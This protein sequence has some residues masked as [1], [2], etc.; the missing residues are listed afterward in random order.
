MT[1]LRKLS[2]FYL[3]AASAFTMAAVLQQHPDWSR[4]A[5]AAA[6]SIR[7]TTG[8]AATALNQDVI[9]PGWR[10][11]KS[12]ASAFNSGVLQPGWTFT[13]TQSK[14]FAAWMLA[15]LAP[16]PVHVAEAKK[17]QPAKRAPVVP[18][19]K[20]PPVL[21]RNAAPVLRPSITGAQPKV[22]AE[23]APA[24]M[25]LAPQ[26]PMAAP[27]PDLHPPGQAEIARVSERLRD[28]LTPDMLDHFSLFLFVSKAADG[29]LAQ[30]MYVYQKEDDGNLSL[31]YNWPVS[32]GRE[33]VEFS[34]GGERAPSF[35]PD[36]Y[37]ELDPDRH[38]RRYRSMQWDQ[39]M[40]Y[41]MFFN[42]VHDGFQTGLAIHGASGE[43]IGLLGQ[44]ASA[45]CIRLAPQ[46][47]QV[48]FE[49]IQKNYKGLMPKFAYD[50]KTATM[51]NDGVIVHNADGHVELTEGYKV[52]VLIENFD[53]RNVVA[54]LF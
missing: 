19:P 31:L 46:N 36:G 35:T 4:Q 42:W 50:K 38:Y 11:A 26:Q 49:L 52:L 16:K 15:E 12:A 13:E 14:A 47:A 53:G 8:A 21:A 33:K 40:P 6:T 30:R 32:T 18:T 1:A 41:A 24:P 22:E 28:S 3:V 44:R 27:P 34:P 37:Y 20:P 2:A 51:S 5:E 17:P 54:A 23:K 48:L 9:Q 29:P 43:D 45:G 39:P 7:G 25:Q 10:I